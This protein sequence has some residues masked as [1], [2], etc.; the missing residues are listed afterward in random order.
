MEQ[1]TNESVRRRRNNDEIIKLLAE[2]EKSPVS[3][4]EFCGRHSI[5]NATFYKWQNKYRDKT[6]EGLG[7]TGFAHLQI[8][9]SSANTVASLFAEV[10]GIRIYQSVAASYLKEL[11]V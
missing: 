9:S 1:N 2:F 3:I 11:S 6:G 8:S 5:S 10:K 4:K 7:P